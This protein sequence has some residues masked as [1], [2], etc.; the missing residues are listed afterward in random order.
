MK[1]KMLSIVVIL[2]L[3]LAVSN[4]SYSQTNQNFTYQPD[5]PNPGQKITV[6]YNPAGT[7]LDLSKPL[8]MLVHAYGKSIYYTDEIDLTKDGD[9]YKGS[10]STADTCAG[11]VIR[12]TDGENF[13]NNNS[14][15]FPIRYYGNNG[16]FTKY[17]SA[18]L[19]GGYQ[20]WFGAFRIDPDPT[21]AFKLF[22]EEFALYPDVTRIYLG[23]YNAAYSKVD[24]DKAADFLKKEIEK[25]EK[26]LTQSLED[27][28]FLMDLYAG[29]KMKDKV[30]KIK[31]VI[32]EKY[33]QSPQAELLLVQEYFTIKEA[34]KKLEFANKFKGQFPNSKYLTYLFP[35]QTN[36]LIQTGNYEDAYQALKKN[37]KALSNAYN[38]LAWTMYEKDANLKLAKEIAAKG[39]ELTKTE[40]PLQGSPRPPYYSDKQFKKLV[41]T[42]NY[43]IIDTY[44]AILLKLGE[45]AEALKYMKEAYE[46][47]NGR[48]AD[49]SERYMQALI[50]NGKYSESVPMLEKFISDGKSTPAMKDLLKEAF[51]KTKGSE[52][53]FGEYLSTLESKA[54]KSVTEELKKKMIDQPA[55]KFSLVGLDGKNVSLESLKGKIV[56]VDFW[57]TWCGPCKASFPGMQKAVDKFVNDPNVK[58]LFINTWENVDDKKKNAEDFITQNKYTFHVLLDTDNKVIESYK[59]DGIPTKF[60][61]DKNGNIRFKS[62]G[63]DG[64]ADK[65]VDELS[66]MIAML[67]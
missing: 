49:V 64:S 53:G 41:G 25:Y 60:I 27:L 15:C 28:S 12:F 3:L 2:F 20:Y 19:A 36:S 66:S 43:A 29:Q 37:P 10:F 50:V 31:S 22:E 51:V 32:F 14:K 23:Q 61:I 30:E 42:S 5:K 67:K 7:K 38:N 47:N 52:S 11:V 4:H 35:D 8:S 9:L 58:F 63:F 45:N 46:L 57:A 54:Q 34:E 21:T 55:P 16:K 44:G 18:G 40:D 39:I 65:L 62:V 13:D 59:V 24:K 26:T 1:K 56:I 17:A 6:V 33:P 48:S